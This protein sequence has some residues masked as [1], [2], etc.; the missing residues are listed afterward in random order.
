MERDDAVVATKAMS[1]TL[2]SI[3]TN[4]MA[5]KSILRPEE[6]SRNLVCFLPL[7]FLLRIPGSQDVLGFRY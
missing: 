5:A 4:L 7:A 1:A 2:H 6:S 3:V